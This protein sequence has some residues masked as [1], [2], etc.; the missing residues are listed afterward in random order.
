MIRLQASDSFT[1]SKTI[2]LEDGPFTGYQ[3]ILIRPTQPF[4]FLRLPKELQLQVYQ[5]Y[6]APTCNAPLLIDS[7]RGLSKAPFAKKYAAGS[8]NRVALLA[9]NKEINESATPV[10]Y[11]QTITFESTAFLLEYLVELPAAAREKL[12]HVEARV[13][14]RPSARM[15]LNLLAEA[16]NINKVTF[17]TGVGSGHDIEKIATSFFNDS[18]KFLES[19]AANT[20]D[21]CAGMRSFDFGNM[22]LTV[23]AGDQQKPWTPAMVKR[24]VE[25]IESKL[26]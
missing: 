21:R 1:L 6:F 13:Y 17:T 15:A 18:S 14:H 12:F 16:R 19:K 26:R 11:H 10:L 7:R 22:A 2:L 25:H 24:F 5:Y 8:R 4:P 23:K 9:V 20:G 3:A